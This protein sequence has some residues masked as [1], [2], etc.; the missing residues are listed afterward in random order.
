MGVN[1]GPDEDGLEP[2]K[3][4]TTPKRDVSEL[5]R[6]RNL[7]GKTP[8][9]DSNRQGG[10]DAESSD[11]EVDMK[12]MSA[13]FKETKELIALCSE[14]DEQY[15]AAKHD[16]N[17]FDEG[18]IDTQTQLTVLKACMKLLKEAI[19]QQNAGFD[20]NNMEKQI[21]EMLNKSKNTMKSLSVL[22]GEFIST[23]EIVINKDTFA[24]KLPLVKKARAKQISTL[25][26][27][28][29]LADQID[30]DKEQ[31][32]ELLAHYNDFE[33]EQFN[34][35]IAETA[36]V[37]IDTKELMEEI[38]GQYLKMLDDIDVVKDLMAVIIPSTKPQIKLANKINAE[39]ASL[40]KTLRAVDEEM[41]RNEQTKDKLDVKHE[42]CKEIANDLTK[43][44]LEEQTDQTR[45]IS[46]LV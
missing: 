34:W 14:F 10:R 17:G 42:D 9:E 32:V 22:K 26:K 24:L 6:R 35:E 29:G 16:F 23:N 40:E 7:G 21:G 28:V 12:V 39:I 15:S 46:Q 43:V 41:E 18:Q 25:T 36:K 2:A 30:E 20:T 27:F 31:T 33:K 11:E 3:Q 8:V 4:Q 38:D 19:Y 1:G 13:N 45:K 5:R 37:V 44:E